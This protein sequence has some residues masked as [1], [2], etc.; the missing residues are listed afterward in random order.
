MRLTLKLLLKLKSFTSLRK[1]NFF[2]NF[3]SSLCSCHFI[4]ITNLCTW[5]HY[6]TLASISVVQ[7]FFVSDSNMILY[8]FLEWYHDFL[9]IPLAVLVEYFHLGYRQRRIVTKL[10]L[11]GIVNITR[12]FNYHFIYIWTCKEITKTNREMILCYNSE[13]Y[14]IDII[15]IQTF[16]ILS[17]ND[18]DIFGFGVC[19]PSLSNN[20]SS[21]KSINCCCNSKNHFGSLKNTFGSFKYLKLITRVQRPVY[22]PVYNF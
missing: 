21:F 8:N 20:F 12:D 14:S 11:S 13:W 16:K 3:L 2:D 19:S 4:E 17:E 18:L 1:W 22:I 7:Q 5:P 6:K 15:D 10:L 9:L